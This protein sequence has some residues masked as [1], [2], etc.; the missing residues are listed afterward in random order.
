MK[1]NLKGTK[2]KKEK[3]PKTMVLAED[4]RA[5]QNFNIE[6]L[7]SKAIEQGVSPETMEKFLAM[8]K[9]L[10]AEWAKE[11]FDSAMASF[12]AECPTIKKDEAVAFGTTKYNYAS[13]DKIVEQVK[14]LLSK[15]G[16]SY[17]FDTK[18]TDTGIVIY[19]LVKH[20]AGHSEKSECTIALDM[21]TKMNVSQKSGSAMTYGKRYAF[22]NAFGILTGDKDDD[23]TS[24]N[25]VPDKEDAKVSAVMKGIAGLKDE[26]TALLWLD[27]LASGPLPESQKITFKAMIEEKI[28]TFKN[29]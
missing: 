16:F 13:L 11:Q 19:C 14:P 22:C 26:K 21:S 6:S 25:T 28:K 3:E 9:E 20:T 17:T 24:L 4:T 10:K 5:I 27:K 29:E 15:N 1:N 2:M 7:M 18:E 8:R 12:Q 23:A